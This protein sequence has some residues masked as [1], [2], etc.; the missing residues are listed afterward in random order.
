M[1]TVNP[2]QL[3][4]L[5]VG[6]YGSTHLVSSPKLPRRVLLVG[7]ARTWKT[8]T[9]FPYPRLA[10]TILIQG[11]WL[12]TIH[13]HPGGVEIPTVACPPVRAT[14]VYEKDG[15]MLAHEPAA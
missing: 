2:L 12:S 6:K 7:L 15:V 11:L 5:R 13:K 9:P 8:T 14:G 1:V 10:E 4:K 3:V